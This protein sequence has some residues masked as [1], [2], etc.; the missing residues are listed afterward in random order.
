MNN[1]EKVAKAAAV[2][3]VTTLLSRIFGFVRDMVVAW[4]FG[5][6]MVADAFYV[7]YRVPSLL[8]ELLAE[9]SISA[10]FIP[11]FTR[12]LNEEGQEEARRLVKATFT[13]LI[14]IL[15]TVT[16]IGIIVA[17]LLVSLIAPG[18]HSAAGGKFD[19]TVQLTRIMF[20]YLLF[21]SLAALAMGI[22]NTLGSFAISSLSSI[23][24]SIFMICGVYIFAPRFSVPVYG[25]ATG[26]I[27][28]GIA[29]FACQLPA[30]SR[31]KMMLGWYFKPS[32]PGV[33]QIG[34]LIVPMILGLSVTQVNIFV[35]TVLSS[36]LKEGSITYLYYGIRLI[37]FPLGIFGVAMASAVL[38]TL[39]AAAVKREYDE[40]RNTYSF[41]IRLILF[42]TLPAMTGLI[43]LRIPIISVLFQSRAFDYA[44]TLGTADALLYYSVGL[45]A[46]TGTRITA[47]AFYSMQ[48]TNT[49]V[50][51]AAVAVAVN[52]IVS[53]LLMGPLQHGGLALATSLASMANLS[54]LVW[55]LRKRLGHLNLTEIVHSLKK[56]V[57]ATLIMGVIAWLITR[58]DVWASGGQAS[59]KI[60][61][62]FGSILLSSIAYIVIL[63]LLKSKELIF[64][65]NMAVRKIK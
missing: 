2:M 45:W 57:P 28:G 32:H 55:V 52:I 26:V 65:W 8:R 5:A 22:L 50:K 51:A 44:A 10:A 24:L 34:K 13:I 35:N 61:L 4:A 39:S 16:V 18:F 11:V 21:V 7:A 12:H 47:Q 59:I 43:I 25:L 36:L 41:A 3:G 6:G 27:I 30:L 63:Y 40:M 58:G 33:I 15:T 56:V 64:L 54:V 37:H 1:Q 38:P 31:R 49:P 9:G 14:I 20:P 42:I 19:L 29:Q 53:L 60:G 23:T 17:P 46:F 48:D 62:L